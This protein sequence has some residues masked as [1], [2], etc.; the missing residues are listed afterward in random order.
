MG[1]GGFVMHNQTLRHYCSVALGLIGAAILLRWAWAPS[2]DFE[3]APVTGQVSIAN[4]PAGNLVVF[5][6]PIDR[7]HLY[8]SGRVLP[9]GS[10]H[11][12]Y[13]NGVAQYEGVMPGKYRVFFSPLGPHR[14]Q[15]AIDHKYLA[16]GTSD[17][18]VEVERD[19]NYVA[20]SLH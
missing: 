13:T 16:P 6:E 17:L 19:W 7:G 15:P 10:F 4:H 8:A 9:D 3:L 20:L 14:P 5:F 12:L 1:E 11:H 2:K 18:L